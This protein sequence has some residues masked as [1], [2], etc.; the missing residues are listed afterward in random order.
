MR[1]VDLS[2]A[3]V[4]LKKK[5]REKK[6]RQFDL[7]PA[8]NLQIAMAASSLI[9]LVCLVFTIF[10]LATMQVS[11]S[12]VFELRFDRFQNELGRDAKGHC[13]DGF[14]TSSPSSSSGTGGRCSEACRTQFRVCLK[15]YQTSIDLSG[16]CT[17]GDFSTPV[18]GENSLDFSA[19]AANSSS[20]VN[21]NK[22]NAANGYTVRLP[23]EFSWPVSFSFS[24]LPSSG[25]DTNQT[26][27]KMALF[28]C[29]VFLPLFFLGHFL[30][31]HRSLSP[32]IQ[33]NYR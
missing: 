24:H 1:S 11:A 2:A 28:F 14:K 30:A 20:S 31:D 6:I 7:R 23:F 26:K 18:L 10:C 8:L 29:F 15:H 4:N 22:D 3:C 33:H 12:G 17:Y 21:A 16:V 27:K 5:K 32:V 13:C 19:A 9:S 25:L